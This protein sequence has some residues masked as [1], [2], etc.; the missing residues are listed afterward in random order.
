MP[1]PGPAEWLRIHDASPLAKIPP[2][3]QYLREAS[4]DD[5]ATWVDPATVRVEFAHLAATQATVDGLRSEITD[6]VVIA[7]ARGGWLTR[8]TPAT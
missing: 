4:Y 8:F 5:G 1:R 6:G 7:E 2:D 3:T